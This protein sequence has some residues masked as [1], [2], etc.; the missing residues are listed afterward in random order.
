MAK[1]IA[2][3]FVLLLVP[4]AAWANIY[5]PSFVEVVS[6]PLMWS[7]YVVTMAIT[8]PVI[9][10]ISYVEARAVRKYIVDG[11][12]RK[13]FAQL[14]V[15]N[16]ITSLIRLPFMGR[17][18]VWPGLPVSY[19]LTIPAEALLVMLFLR[20]LLSVK[21]VGSALVISAR[22][23]TAS[24][25][26]LTVIIL[27]MIYIPTIG[28][29]HPEV[30]RDAVG[31]L[32]IGADT[33]CRVLDLSTRRF[34]VGSAQ[35][36]SVSERAECY[37]SDARGGMIWVVAS[38]SAGMNETYDVSIV[39]SRVANGR[40]VDTPIG[41]VTKVHEVEAVSGDGSLLVC[42]RADKWLILRSSGETFA[43]L[44]ERLARSVSSARFSPDC[45][46][47]LVTTSREAPLRGGMHT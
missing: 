30:G 19:V 43:E 6:S 47:L 1:R 21:S 38:E 41:K 3:L 39:S 7:I 11:T 2:F 25:A 37:A 20:K 33:D 36:H 31:L 42:R 13:V 24:Y 10:L 15:L 16:A 26:L 9:L 12:F 29:E 44:P 8:V 23:N 40:W 46:H 45:R 4:T 14:C 17:Q 35:R 5:V 34:V 32:V 27:G 28:A 18:V 22:M